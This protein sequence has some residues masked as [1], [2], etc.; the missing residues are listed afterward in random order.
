MQSLT[1]RIIPGPGSS[2][3]E[4]EN[5][6]QQL[7]ESHQEIGITPVMAAFLVRKASALAE[8]IKERPYTNED[9]EWKGEVEVDQGALNR[10]DDFLLGVQESERL[11]GEPIVSMAL[12]EAELLH[13]EMT[14]RQGIS[15]R[16]DNP[17]LKFVEKSIHRLVN[18]LGQL[19]REEEGEGLATKAHTFHLAIRFVLLRAVLA[20]QLT[21]PSDRQRVLSESII[22]ATALYDH[23]LALIPLAKTP[24]ALHSI[25]ER[26]T[27]SLLRILWTGTGVTDLSRAPEIFEQIRTLEKTPTQ[28]GGKE[29]GPPDLAALDLSLTALSS[30][31]S[32]LS[33]IPPDTNTDNP[34]PALQISGRYWHRLLLTLTLP[35][36][37]TRRLD[38]TR[39]PWTFL[40]RA[41]QLLVDCTTHDAAQRGKFDKNNNTFD[42]KSVVAHLIRAVLI[43]GP[44]NAPG[45]ETVNARLE[46]L[47]DV[48]DKVKQVGAGV[49]RKMVFVMFQ[50][51][52]ATEWGGEGEKEFGKLIL[53]VVWERWQEFAPPE[54]KRLQPVV[55]VKEKEKH[56]VSDSSL[57]RS[58]DS[59]T[60][61][62]PS[63]DPVRIQTSSP[64][65]SLSSSASSPSPTTAP[66]PH[67]KSPQTLPI[68]DNR[69][70]TPSDTP[71][72]TSHSNSTH[73]HTELPPSAPPSSAKHEEYF[74]QQPTLEAV[75]ARF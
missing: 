12:L 42:R 54:W 35:A 43:G 6:V 29:I 11:G 49:N 58:P 16:L 68:S 59:T 27:A 75:R 33:S 67:P 48:F 31:L 25:R 36:C 38:T 52:L 2:P 64:P 60:N 45:E 7:V 4:Y 24:A 74:R 18:Q 30:T 65:H 23:L 40:K 19:K 22:S 61:V 15:T 21:R 56:A 28:I 14:I 51:V 9:T 20:A 17:A 53:E 70:P 8:R 71:L 47:L 69:I 37:R 10:V 26:Q 62:S 57:E 13:L 44:A 73:L 46:F 72:S 34:I 55:P 63:L 66:S 3:S 41:L 32:Y 50:D 5:L 1:L 39:P